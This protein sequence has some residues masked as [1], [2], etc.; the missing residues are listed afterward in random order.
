M[1]FV[2][3]ISVFAQEHNF[4]LDLYSDSSSCDFK[5]IIEMPSGSSANF[6]FHLSVLIQRCAKVKMFLD[7]MPQC[8]F[9][10]IPNKYYLIMNQFKELIYTG[11]VCVSSEHSRNLLCGLIAELGVSE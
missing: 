5:F 11:K 2:A 8:D 4:A 9:I 3:I 10:R 6:D 1:Y 7:F